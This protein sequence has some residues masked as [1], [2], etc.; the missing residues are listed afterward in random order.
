MS[1]PKDFPVIN[2]KF[3]IN[4][5]FTNG[6]IIVLIKK[7]RIEQLRVLIMSKTVTEEWKILESHPRE[8]A[9]VGISSCKTK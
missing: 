3:L 6:Q 8:F 9:I 2:N 7:F 4:R 1:R 5:L